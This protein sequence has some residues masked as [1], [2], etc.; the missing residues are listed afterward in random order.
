MLAYP[1]DVGV[2]PNDTAKKYPNRIGFEVLAYA[3]SET[4]PIGRNS[5]YGGDYF[6]KKIV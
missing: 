5:F 1:V 6:L 2:Y 3:I 4:D